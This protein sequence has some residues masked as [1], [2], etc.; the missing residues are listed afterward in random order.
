MSN[1]REI[2]CSL[3]HGTGELKYHDKM[4]VPCHKCIDNIVE[5]NIQVW[6]EYHGKEKVS[7]PHPA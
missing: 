6:K 1:V 7:Q 2:T 5:S 3:C 4:S